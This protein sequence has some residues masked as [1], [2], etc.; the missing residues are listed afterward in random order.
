MN[1]GRNTNKLAS[2]LRAEKEPACRP[3]ATEVH[4]SFTAWTTE[5]VPIQNWTQERC[6]ATYM[7]DTVAPVQVW[8][9]CMILSHAPV[10]RGCLHYR[11]LNVCRVLGSLPC[12][13]S[14]S[15]GLKNEPILSWF[16]AVEF[17]LCIYSR[18]VIAFLYDWQK[19]WC[20]GS[21]VELESADLLPRMPT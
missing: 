15:V 19:K 6:P 16:L 21:K 13:F 18:W 4:N 10:K 1:F 12:A 17:T 11:K 5:Y 8:P 14:R 2:I 20:R 3:I 9:L 7:Q